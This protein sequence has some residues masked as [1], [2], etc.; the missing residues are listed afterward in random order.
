MTT[1]QRSLTLQFALL[2]FEQVTASCSESL[3]NVNLLNPNTVKKETVSV[4]MCL[5]R[6]CS[7]KKWTIF[8]GLCP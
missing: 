5:T 7:V 1:L 8:L 4:N 3:H 6:K 2:Y